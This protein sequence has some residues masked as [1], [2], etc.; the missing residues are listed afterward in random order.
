V[1]SLSQGRTAAAQCG[2]FTHKSVPVIFEPP[3]TFIINLL[4][5]IFLPLL[6]FLPQPSAS[7]LWENK[8]QTQEKTFYL[9]AVNHL[10][11]NGHY[12]GRTAQLTSRC[13]ILYIYS[14]NI[15]NEYFKHAAW[16]PFSSLQN[17]IY[18]IMLAFLVPVLFTF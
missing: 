8:F 9:T 14:T 6:Y 13:R 2:L 11:P 7:L 16:S 5:N 3:C 12:M 10:T 17:A 15:R 1:A 18:F 4:F